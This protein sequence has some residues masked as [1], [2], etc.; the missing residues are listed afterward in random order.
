MQS[1]NLFAPIWV[2]AGARAEWA[3]CGVQRHGAADTWTLGLLRYASVSSTVL[4]RQI[5]RAPFFSFFPQSTNTRLRSVV[6]SLPF[7]NLKS[8][9]TST[10]DILTVITGTT[11]STNMRLRHT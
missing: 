9:L 11:Q 10:L 2:S 4:Y 5:P 1:T 6:L 8:N 3:C 7:L